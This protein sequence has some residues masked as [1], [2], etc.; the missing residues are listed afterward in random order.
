MPALPMPMDEEEPMMEES[1]EEERGEE[2]ETSEE[3][4]ELLVKRIA[5]LSPEEK[6]QLDELI[7]PEVAG[8]LSRVLPELSDIIERVAGGGEDRP[9]GNSQAGALSGLMG[10]PPPAE[11]EDEELS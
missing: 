6:A 3:F 7:T 4:R 2:E 11:D 9:I 8:I 1:P 5:S 10:A